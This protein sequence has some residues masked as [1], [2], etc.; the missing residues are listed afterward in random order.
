MVDRHLIIASNSNYY[1]S[2]LFAPYFATRSEIDLLL[3]T[4]C[5]KIL[6]IL[7]YLIRQEDFEA[8][9]SRKIKIQERIRDCCEEISMAEK[10]AD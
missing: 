5:S 7:C 3:F 1:F 6:S 10:F 2:V 9:S 4:F 8:P